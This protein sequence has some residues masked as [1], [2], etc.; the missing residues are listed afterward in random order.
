MSALDA[1]TGDVLDTKT[2]FVG[3][4]RP[5]QV[6]PGVWDRPDYFV[7]MK[8]IFVEA[9][10][11][12]AEA[13]AGFDISLRVYGNKKIKIKIQRGAIYPQTYERTVGGQGIIPT[14]WLWT[15]PLI[16]ESY[17]PTDEQFDPTNPRLYSSSVKYDI[18]IATASSDYF[19]TGDIILL[20]YLWDDETTPFDAIL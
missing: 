8:S 18:Q 4:A 20:N 5:D 16:S 19:R 14:Q 7:K 6:A 2:V 9:G 13:K 15:W 17:G 12:A 11:T 10:Q 3:A 1:S